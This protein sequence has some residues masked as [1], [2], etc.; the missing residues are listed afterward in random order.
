MT[1]VPGNFYSPQ[2]IRR[3]LFMLEMQIDNIKTMVGMQQRQL[4]QI[5]QALQA[6]RVDVHACAARHEANHSQAKGR[7]ESEQSAAS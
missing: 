1:D 6:I 5:D 2:E 3:T 7:L 4:I